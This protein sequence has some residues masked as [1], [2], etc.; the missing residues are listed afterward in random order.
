[1]RVGCDVLLHYEQKLGR[2]VGWTKAVKLVSGSFMGTCS[3]SPH[4]NLLPL[5]QNLVFVGIQYREFRA[6]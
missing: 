4:P 6:H 3:L 1:M 2:H 5:S